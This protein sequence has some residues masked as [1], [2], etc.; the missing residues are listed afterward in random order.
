M[1][2]SA[3]RW[4]CRGA[5]AKNVS[6]R[7]IDAHRPARARAVKGSFGIDDTS[8]H[9]RRRLDPLG[10]IAQGMYSNDGRGLRTMKRLTRCVAVAAILLLL[11]QAGHT[12]SA[13]QAR[14][15]DEE[16]KSDMDLGS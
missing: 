1:P 11:L 5:S 14:S 8:D 13:E 6:R 7:A 16:I 3:E 4:E 9:G 10:E 15:D 2:R 12:A